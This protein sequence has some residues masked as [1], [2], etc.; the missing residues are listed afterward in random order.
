[1]MYLHFRHAQGSQ[2]I[3]LW[4]CSLPQS[5]LAVQSMLLL[6]VWFRSE[7]IPGLRYM[8]GA[9]LGFATIFA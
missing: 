4:I 8:L 6:Q 1:M 5:S 2:P 3:L 9:L 7:P